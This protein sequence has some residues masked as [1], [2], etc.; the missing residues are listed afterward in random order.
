MKKQIF[1][2]NLFLEGVRQLAPLGLAF[3]A[4]LALSAAA[5][6][7]VKAAGVA[8][9]WHFYGVKSGA[10]MS[11]CT[12][13]VL[14][15]QWPLLFL[16]CAATPL[17]S[18]YLFRFLNKRSSSDFYHALP[19]TRTA[20][21]FS[22]LGASFFWMLIC[23]VCSVGFSI[24]SCLVCQKYLIFNTVGIL[25][26]GFNLLLAA[27]L[28]LAGIGM[29]VSLTGNTFSNITVALIILFLPRLYLYSI[30]STP[31]ALLPFV[32][33]NST[34]IFAPDINLTVSL[35]ASVLRVFNGNGLAAFSF[36]TLKAPQICYTVALTVVYLAL[37]C[38][39]FNRRK[40]ESANSPAVSKRLQAA[41]RILVTL[42]PCILV[43]RSITAA[44]VGSEKNNLQ[45]VIFGYFIAAL[46]Y[47]GYEL[48]ATKRWR[49]LLKAAP[50]LLVVALLNAV[51][52]FTMKTAYQRELNF[53]P[54][55]GQMQSVSFMSGAA[56][57][58]SALN[59]DSCVT[60]R[61]EQLNF[62]NPEILK[63]VQAKLAETVEL[64]KKDP[65]LDALYTALYTGEHNT[66]S[67]KITANGRTAYRNLTLTPQQ[68]QQLNALVLKNS[69]YLK[70]WQQP[71]AALKG[72]IT[73]QSY[74]NQY[75]TTVLPEQSKEE[76]L[77]TYR[78]ELQ[79]IDLAAYIKKQQQNEGNALEI[80]CNS[81]INGKVYSIYYPVFEDLFP[82]TC[83]SCYTL[84]YRAQKGDRA[85][86]L[87]LAN[88]EFAGLNGHI[89]LTAQKQ[90][91][92]AGESQAIYSRRLESAQSRSEAAKLLKYCLTH[93]VD[94]APT[95]SDDAFLIQVSL[96]LP[97]GENA[98][99]QDDYA[100]F[101][102]AAALD[103]T[104]L[105]KEFSQAAESGETD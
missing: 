56:D 49:G 30:S 73:V 40:S 89:T 4:L 36:N 82:K 75:S 43:C 67:F 12:V 52:I 57:T 45:T 20:L 93:A 8:E 74:R 60:L 6:P 61:A 46:V 95:F 81:V 32:Y 96:D 83:Q 3:A 103:L 23:A 105:P 79:G 53:N 85:D 7:A 68:L 71:P 94:R 37:G 58:D 33:E 34:G 2:K 14:E 5:L 77:E 65:L 27:A 98:E 18:L 54:T 70:L 78:E 35:V 48:I 31:S 15:L 90:Q 86:L 19:H 47:F 1:S 28:A 62:T 22:F 102:P 24:L 64:V 99:F 87:K 50:G 17:L 91:S 21:Y 11:K 44:W 10:E 39:L 76:L 72:T 25:C 66:L 97:A 42:L 41:F 84:A 100:V 63:L 104:A 80:G 38:L 26:N 55:A 29:A 59:A 101:L 88:T 51:M 92:R 9:S 13:E 69:D 16:P